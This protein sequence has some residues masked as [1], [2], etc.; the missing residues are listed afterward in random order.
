M[1]VAIC[2]NAGVPSCMRVPPETGLASSGSRSA[3]ARATQEV[4]SRAV[5]R[6]TDPPRNANSPATTA[7]RR[8]CSRPSPTTTASSV[9]ARS[10]ARAS[11]SR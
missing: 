9:P 5:A 8:P 7:T 3:V 1:T 2:T 11:S 10:R 4:S 6:P